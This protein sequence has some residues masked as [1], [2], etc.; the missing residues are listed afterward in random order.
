MS[1]LQKR[2][3]PAAPNYRDY[4]V[5]LVAWALDNAAL[6]RAGRL[7]E[8]DAQHLAEELEDLGKSERRSLG[9]HLRVLVTH[10][11]KWQYQPGLRGASWRLSVLNARAAI[12]GI[13]ADSPSLVPETPRHLDAVYHL[14]RANAIGETGLPEA[15][16][17]PDCPYT[18]EQV[19]SET[20]WPQ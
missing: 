14:A 8:V 7:S 15:S 9:S 16:F 5:D 1:N 13:L 4:E 2:V 11:L 6:L 18:I 10:L 3:R 20:F 12:R 17:P 19:L